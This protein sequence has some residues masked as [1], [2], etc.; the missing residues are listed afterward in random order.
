MQRKAWTTRSD[1]YVARILHYEPAVGYSRGVNAKTSVAPEAKITTRIGRVRSTFNSQRLPRSEMQRVAWRCRPD[2]DVA[3]LVDG[4]R[5]LVSKWPNVLNG[6][7]PLRSARP[8]SY[9]DR[10]VLDFVRSCKNC[11]R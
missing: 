6:Q 1:T 11:P 8:Y 9:G 5:A 10:V 2:S 7:F 4:E 3:V